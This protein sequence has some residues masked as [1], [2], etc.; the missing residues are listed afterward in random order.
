MQFFLEKI[1]TESFFTVCEE[2]K[3]FLL[4]VIMGGVFGV[5]FDV[6]RAL[7]VIFPILKGTIPT[8]ICD[9]LYIIICAAGIFLFSLIFARGEV[10]LYYVLGAVPGF[11]I[12]M[13]TAGTVI[14]GIIRSIFGTVYSLISRL[15]K[16]LAGKINAVL[17]TSESK[18]DK[19]HADKLHTK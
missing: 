14:M 3:L 9:A 19:R 16:A 1:E 4:S 5:V 18:A 10:R 15:F 2:A 6:F 7:R 8:M 17:H 12:Y 13:L 11:V